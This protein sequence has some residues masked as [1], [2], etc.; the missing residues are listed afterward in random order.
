MRLHVNGRNISI[1]PAIKEYVKEKF[2]KISH[3]YD[4]VLSIEVILGVTKNP[5]VAERHAAEA[6]CMVNGTNIHVT[7]HAES[8][9][10]CIDLLADKLNRQVIKHKEK[11]LKSKNKSASI[12]SSSIE[13]TEEEIEEPEEIVQVEIKSEE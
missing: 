2:A 13:E 5:S 10:A 11:L 3:H 1:T 4:Q 12:R 6:I 7:E 9:Y 8:M